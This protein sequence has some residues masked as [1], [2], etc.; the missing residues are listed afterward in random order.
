LGYDFSGAIKKADSLSRSGRCSLG[1]C[2]NVLDACRVCQMVEE[3]RC[4]PGDDDPR[5]ERIAIMPL[6][7]PACA[8]A[9]LGKAIH[10]SRSPNCAGELRYVRLQQDARLR[11]QLGG[12]LPF[13]D[14]LLELGA[15]LDASTALC[16]S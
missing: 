14:R 4:F 7:A 5:G 1:S 12:T 11:Q 3:Q 2:E 9:F 13:A 15:L 10:R 8:V 6:I 16:T